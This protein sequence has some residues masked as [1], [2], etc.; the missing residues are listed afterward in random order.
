MRQRAGAGRRR[1][2]RDDRGAMVQERGGT[3]DI[4]YDMQRSSAIGATERR[5]GTSV[6]EGLHQVAF[7][8]ECG[9]AEWIPA[10]LGARD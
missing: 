6:E 5:V 7:A 9:D 3:A 1:R 10:V 8:Q 2:A 4:V